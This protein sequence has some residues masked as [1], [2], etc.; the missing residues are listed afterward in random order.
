MSLDG[1]RIN[2]VFNLSVAIAVTEDLEQ[3]THN[4][5]VNFPPIVDFALFF[6]TLLCLAFFHTL[7]LK[8]GL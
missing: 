2:L 7:K 8:R 6:L 1:F 5:L 4:V 3:V